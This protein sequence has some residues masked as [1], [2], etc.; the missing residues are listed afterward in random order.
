MEAPPRDPEVTSSKEIVELHLLIGEMGDEL[1]AY[2]WREAVWISIVFHVLIFLGIIFVPKW[3]PKSPVIIP[4]TDTN[5]DISFVIDPSRPKPVK[6][7]P[8]DKVS[9]QNRMAQSPRPTL[10]KD[11]LRKL[12]DMQRA[13]RP[14]E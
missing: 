14:A 7:P 3:I 11:Q 6:P 1:S 4:L 12:L 10:N 2:R 13:G 5:K 9:D 8:T